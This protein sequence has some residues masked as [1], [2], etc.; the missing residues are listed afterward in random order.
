VAASVRDAALCGDALVLSTDNGLMVW[1]LHTR[2]TLWRR[3]VSA[4][5]AARDCLI[6][7]PRD[8]NAQIVEPSTGKSIGELPERFSRGSASESGARV[9]LLNTSR[10]ETRV[11]DVATRKLVAAVPCFDLSHPF[12]LDNGNTLAIAGDERSI[13][14]VNLATSR[15]GVLRGH[16]GRVLC[17]AEIPGRGLLLSGGLDRTIR[18]WDL[19]R[20]EEVGELR[21]HRDRVTA[22]V[23]LPDERSVFSASH[24]Y[25]IRRWDTFPR[26]DLVQAQRQ[27]EEEVARLAPWMTRLLSESHDVATVVAR[28]EASQDLTP[29]Q[30]QIARQL[31]LGMAWNAES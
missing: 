24:D 14:V 4:V 27:Y 12:L 19:R 11:Y 28:I 18:V 7:Q 8:S 21:E 13:S 31:L 2:Q 9:A 23:A 26:R 1:D 15:R 6:V 29:R 17:V 3:D 30:R 25:T 10:N 22:L 16:T 20:M 5:I